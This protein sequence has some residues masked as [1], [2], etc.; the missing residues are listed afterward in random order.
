M[1]QF[2]A[3]QGLH[4]LEDERLLRGAGRY[5]DDIALPGQVYGVLLRSPLAH[6]RIGAIDTADA[7]A[8]P[9]VL[10]VYTAADLAADGIGDIP[11]LAPV[12]GKNGT[13]TILPPNPV[14]ARDV[15]RHV[16]D[17]VAF[18]VAESLAEAKDAAEA[19][20]VDYEDL[21][22]VIDTERAQDAGAPQVYPEA[23]GN[24]CVLWAQ[25]NEDQTAAAFAKAPRRAARALRSSTTGSWST[26]S[27]RAWRW[28]STTARASA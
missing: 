12:P 9:G 14:L 6:A 10:A 27:S 24:L 25:G 18:V 23:P 5:T 8:M 22:A 1:G 21:P 3:G 7:K 16:G 4:R 20:M 17:P 28:A 15:V 11:C 2:G 13:E 19:V 26:P